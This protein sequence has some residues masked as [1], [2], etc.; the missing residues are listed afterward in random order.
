[1]GAGMAPIPTIEITLGVFKIG[2]R[3]TGVNRLITS[4]SVTA[5]ELDSD[6]VSAVPL[7]LHTQNRS[8]GAETKNSTVRTPGGR[9]QPHGKRHLGCFVHHPFE[10]HVRAAGAQVLK[11]GLFLEGLIVH[12]YTPQPRGVRS[13]NSRTRPSFLHQL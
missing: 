11:Y 9:G 13:I 6:T 3:S 10:A 2:I 5:Q 12:V 1:M 8:A 4:A 7:R